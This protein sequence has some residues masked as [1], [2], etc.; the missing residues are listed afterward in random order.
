ME[1]TTLGAEF[2]QNLPAILGAFAL[3]IGSVAATVL[4][5]LTFRRAGKAVESS[6]ANAVTLKGVE[7]KVDGMSSNL[8]SATAGQKLAE[9]QLKERDAERA[10]QDTPPPLT[11]AKEDPQLVKI[12]KP[13][14][15][16]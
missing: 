6:K 12:V 4:S 1:P 15:E 7:T 13:D 11:S 8:V 5:I 2:I 14:I 3:F 10:Y 9:G 16:L